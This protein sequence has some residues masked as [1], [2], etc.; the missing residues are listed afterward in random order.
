MPRSAHL[1]P[2]RWRGQGRSSEITLPRL[3]RRGVE[4]ILQQ[5]INYSLFP[6]C[7]FVVVDRPC[8]YQYWSLVR[9]LVCSDHALI[10]AG[11]LGGLT[12]VFPCCMFVVGL[13]CWIDRCLSTLVF[14]VG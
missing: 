6:C 9:S 3:L 12:V 10:S 11:L 8:A 14:G 13:L 2:I 4:G 1:S 5:C 7:V